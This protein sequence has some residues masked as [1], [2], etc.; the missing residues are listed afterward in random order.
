MEPIRALAQRMIGGTVAEKYRLER[1]IGVGGHGAVFEARHAWTG[2]RVALKVLLGAAASVRD[3]SERFLREARAAAKVEH[4]GVVEVLDMGRDEALGGLYLVVEFLE[5]ED[6]KAR[7]A[8]RGH[9]S[10]REAVTLLLPVMRGLA[11]AHAVGVLHRDVK[12]ANIFLSRAADGSE[13]AKLID[14]G[15]SRLLAREGASPLTLTGSPVG[16]PE[17]MSPEQARGDAEVDGRSDIWGMAVVLYEAL[18]GARPFQGS[19]YNALMFRI[20][21]EPPVP[22]STRVPSLPSWLVEAVHRGLE[23]SPDDRYRAMEDFVTALDGRRESLSSEAPVVVTPLS[24]TSAAPTPVPE[25]STHDTLAS[26]APRVVAPPRV[27]LSP[28]PL[29][30]DS[31]TAALARGEPAATLDVASAEVDRAAAKLRRRGRA[32][33]V[34]VLVAVAAL[35]AALAVKL[36]PRGLRVPPVTPVATPVATRPRVPVDAALLDASVTPSSVAERAV[37]ERLFGSLVRSV[38]E[39]ARPAVRACLGATFF[40]QVSVMF[41]VRPD[42]SVLRA[43]PQGPLAETSRGRCVAETL[44]ALRFPATRGRGLSRVRWRY[45][46]APASAQPSAG[47]R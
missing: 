42:G 30:P 8:Q 28:E 18:S 45:V 5:G 39:P 10:P 46:F 37:F 12:P 3:A 7:L 20:A 21:L 26:P 29:S 9:L 41:V 16:T 27:D 33:G 14:F 4:E 13:S 17:Y 2:R 31:L 44:G 36:Q 25:P 32:F 24:D 6:L 22:L 35:S 43:E 1:L 19:S 34:S 11:V 47:A 15:V 23:K 38:A 40:G